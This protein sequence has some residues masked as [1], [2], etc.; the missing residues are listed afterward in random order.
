MNIWVTALRAVCTWAAKQRLIERNP[1][2]GCSVP[3]PKKVRHRDTQ[4]FSTDEIR[5]IL[6]NASAI[7]DTTRPAMAVRRWVPWICAYSGARAGEIT[8][9]RGQ[10]VVERDGIKALRITPDAG[11]VKT[12]QARTV[13]LHE[14]LIAQ[15]FLDFVN[16]KGKGRYFIMPSRR[17]PRETSQT[18]SPH[19]LL[20]RAT[21]LGNGCVP[22]ALPIRRQAPPTAGVTRSSR[23]PTGT[24]FPTA[25]QMRSRATRRRLRA[26]LMAPRRWRTWQTR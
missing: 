11:A 8:Q 22:S 10:D 19:G 5:L 4:A 7:K 15:G 23:L 3:I 25:C 21:T 18:P 26:E 17:H 24:A 12:R 14:H 9:L 2:V 1:F 6:S 13:P 20:K 16:S